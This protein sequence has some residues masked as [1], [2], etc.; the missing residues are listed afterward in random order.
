M[1]YVFLFVVLFLAYNLN[2]QNKFVGKY[3]S[4]GLSSGI[5]LLINEDFSFE[6][7]MSSH[8]QYDGAKGRIFVINDTIFFKY[9]KDNTPKDSSKIYATDI[10]SSMAQYRP[11]KLFFSNDKLYGINEN[12]K[13]VKKVKRQLVGNFIRKGDWKKWYR[14]KYYLFG[15]YITKRVNIYYVLK[16]N[17]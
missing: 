14:K 15:P 5:E 4:N 2:A 11:Q 7:S 6:Y 8:T 10:V 9:N 12:G 1:K 13:I 17:Q 3:Y 16:V